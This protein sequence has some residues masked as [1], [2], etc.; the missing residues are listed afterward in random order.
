MREASANPP[1]QSR[2]MK[3]AAQRAAKNGVDF[4]L[5]RIA[6]SDLS[7]G[8][9]DVRRWPFAEVFDAH[10]A[11]DAIEEMSEIMQDEARAAAKR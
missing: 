3:R 11:L 8:I 2:A 7:Q 4:F 1:E 5:Y 10:L 6:R 9:G